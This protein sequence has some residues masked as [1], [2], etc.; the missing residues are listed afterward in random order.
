MDWLWILDNLLGVLLTLAVVAML[1]W[2]Y[3]HPQGRAARRRR[4]R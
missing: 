1:V 2:V 4:D 3:K